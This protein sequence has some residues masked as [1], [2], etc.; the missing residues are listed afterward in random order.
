MSCVKNEDKD[1]Y[2]DV[3]TLSSTD[4][5]VLALMLLYPEKWRELLPRI[6]EFKDALPIFDTFLK[7][8]LLKSINIRFF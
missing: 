1:N 5:R 7:I 6:F 4:D 3:C 2:I 8:S